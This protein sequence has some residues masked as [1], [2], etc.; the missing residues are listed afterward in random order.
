[1]NETKRKWFTPAEIS[2]IVFEGHVSVG[3]VRQMVARGEIPC[4]K[5]GSDTD[6]GGRPIRRRIL[7]PLS[8]V[9]EMERRATGATE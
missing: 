9:Q 3:T 8:Y 5:V 2:K 4:F 6:A 7:I 1:M